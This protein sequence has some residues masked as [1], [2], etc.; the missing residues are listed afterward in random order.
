MS[1]QTKI[2]IYQ[3]I[4]LVIV[5]PITAFAIH[6]TKLLVLAAWNHVTASRMVGDVDDEVTRSVQSP[7]SIAH[8]V[9]GRRENKKSRRRRNRIL[10]AERSQSRPDSKA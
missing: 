10:K 1:L 4:A 6:G 2:I 5:L 7:T 3:L 9:G 8:G